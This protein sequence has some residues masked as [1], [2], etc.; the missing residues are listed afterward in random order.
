MRSLKNEW[1]SY[2]H[3]VSL[4]PSGK[5][6]LISSSGFDAVF[7]YEINTQSKTFEWFAWENGFN[8]AVDEFKKPLFITRKKEI[9]QSWKEKNINFKLI[10]DPHLKELAIHRSN[11]LSYRYPE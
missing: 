3:T 8:Q 4:S 11:P 10:E 5:K 6:I 9:A 1:F 7:E 2:I